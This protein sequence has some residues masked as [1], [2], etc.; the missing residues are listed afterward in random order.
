MH[1]TIFSFTMLLF[2][3]AIISIWI[4]CKHQVNRNIMTAPHKDYNKTKI[5]P[6]STKKTRKCLSCGTE[7][8]QPGRRYCSMQC[9]QKLV[10]VLSLSKG[11]LQA[12]NIKYAT[13][14]FTENHVSLDVMPAWSKTISRFAYKR[15]PG[16]TPANALKDLIL[17]AGEDWHSK[18]NKK[19]SPSLSSQL[20]INEKIEKKI[21]P[22]SVKPDA[23]ITPKLST[24]QKKGLK[25]LNITMESLVE[26]NHE[27]EIK[28]GFW[29]MAKLYHPD[30]GG[31]GERFKEISNAHETLMQWAKNPQFRSNKALPGCW[32]Y[33]G[34]KKR[35]SPPLW[36]SFSQ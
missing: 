30:K 12:L 21:N 34:D 20:I 18:R 6:Y 11:L 27:R 10:W 25:R 31:D 15:K 7:N 28:K 26:G 24:D 14:S 4:Y 33:D 22:D 16:N 32:S 17:E 3:V 8:V 29:E 1:Y 23:N 2:M 13:F 5:F 35:W 36:K 19:I 9:K